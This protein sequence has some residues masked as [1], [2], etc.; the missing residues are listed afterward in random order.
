[1]IFRCSNLAKKCL[2]N[3]IRVQYNNDTNF[4]LSCGTPI[5]WNMTFCSIECSSDFKKIPLVSENC[6]YCGD[7]FYSPISY[8]Q[9]FCCRNCYDNFRSD[10]KLQN[11]N[12]YYDKIKNKYGNQCSICNSFKSLRVHHIDE[13]HGNNKEDNLTLLCE[14]CHRTIHSG[15][16]I[17]I[18]KNLNIQLDKKYTYIDKNLIKFEIGIKD[19]INFKLGSIIKFN[20]LSKI[21][22]LLIE[23]K[24]S[25]EIVSP[26]ILIFYLFLKLRKYKINVVSLKIFDKEN[27]YYEYK[28][29]D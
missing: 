26:E 11:E 24:I 27:N 16:K 17:L 28:K 1:M 13:N 25:K 6:L 2:E 19:K 7:Q 20:E 10:K 18:C 3:Q 12:N 5:S 8:E 29:E 14:S 23:E 22:K 21:L 4:C 9:K 15:I